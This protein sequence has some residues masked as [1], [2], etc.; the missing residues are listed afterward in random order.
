MT[1][2][3]RVDGI[4]RWLNIGLR[5]AVKETIETAMREQRQACADAILSTSYDPVQ[6]MP[7]IY[8]DVVMRADA[9]DDN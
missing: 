8:H 6:P 9:N 2:D 4:C 7:R 1:L 3:E 5:E